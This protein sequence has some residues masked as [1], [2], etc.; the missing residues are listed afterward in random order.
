[1]FLPYAID[2]FI[3]AYNRFIW[4]KIADIVI[5]R[6]GY[7]NYLVYKAIKHD[8]PVVDA[9]KTILTVHLTGS[10]G[11]YAG[12]QHKETNNFNW[13]IMG[14]FNA[15]LGMTNSSQYLTESNN[16]TIELW[17]RPKPVH[18]KPRMKRERKIKR[19]AFIPEIG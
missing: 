10:D 14:T 17:E 9:T 5:G 6:I 16:G 1:M 12:H 13:N 8:V 11:N 15:S 18:L 4:D 7:D 19:A 2:Y 3:I